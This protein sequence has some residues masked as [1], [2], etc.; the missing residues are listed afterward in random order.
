MRKAWWWAALSA[1]IVLL[2]GCHNGGHPQNSTDMRAVNAVIDS[3]PLDVL[4]AGDAKVTGLTYGSTSGF[5][6][7]SSG[8]QEV[9]IRST[10]TQAIFFDKT[11][12]FG[13]GATSTL[14]IYGSR[15]S[16]S[17]M[18]LADDITSPDT[19]PAS[20]NFKIRVAGA[21]ADSGPVD[22]YVTNG[23]DI[24]NA[25][26]TLGAATYGSV[27]AYAE[28]TAGTYVLTLTVAGTKDVLFQSAP[29]QLSAGAVYALA[30]LPSGGGKLSNALLLEQGQGGTG[31]LLANPDGRIKAVNA[32]ADSTTLNFLA[33]GT[34]LLSSVPFAGASDYVPLASGPRTLQL[35][36]SNVPGSI[37]ASLPQQ[38]SAAR[39][40]TVVAV[41][42]I[43]QAQLVTFT[44]DNTAPPAGFAKLRFANAM[45]G[46][47]GTDV[48]VNFAAQAS[49]LA[50]KSA[51]S[52]YTF[53]PSTTYTI[54]FDTAG[55]VSV[56]ATL[57]PAELDAGGV[58]TAYLL[59]TPSSPQVRLV[60]DR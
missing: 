40:Y 20:G 49:G 7:F 47:T 26:A 25:P 30:V 51:S 58:Y 29:T 4:V 15:T 60:R 52:Y 28:T 6:N 46:S 27:S 3:D 36:A 24:S 12:D 34:T 13:D 17:A 19:A 32:I 44:D 54:T 5:A 35:E 11:L 39:D 22:L 53:A 21:S 9:T 37:L 55:A 1:V 41:N 38:V 10:P 48:L 50:F 14:V 56:I 23:T 57:T 8:S 59:G 2:A 31:A 18:L 45:A 33:D 16:L 42:S 43:A